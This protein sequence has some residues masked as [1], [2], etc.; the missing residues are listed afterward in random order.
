[1][2]RL[3]FTQR[4][5]LRSPHSPFSLLPRPAVRTTR[6]LSRR[7]LS[8]A[9]ESQDNLFEYTSGRWVYNDALRH[10]ERKVPSTPTPCAASPP[11]PGGFNRTLLVSPRGGQHVVARVP[12]AVTA[13][14]RLLRHRP[15]GGERRSRTCARAASPRLRYTAGVAEVVDVVRQ[16]AMLE[17]RMMALRFPTGDSLYFTTDL[18]KRFAEP[19]LPLRRERRP[20]YK[21]HPQS[22]AHHVP[23]HHTRPRPSGPA[24]SRF[25]MCHPDLRPA[26]IFVSRF[27]WQH[28]SVLPVFLLAGVPQSLHSRSGDRRPDCTARASHD[29][30]L[31]LPALDIGTAVRG[32]HSAQAGVYR[33]LRR[34]RRAPYVETRGMRVPAVRAHAASLSASSYRITRAGEDTIIS[35]APHVP[36]LMW[37]LHTALRPPAHA[38]GPGRPSVVLDPARSA[39]RAPRDEHIPHIPPRPDDTA[40]RTRIAPS[41]LESVDRLTAARPTWLTPRKPMSWRPTTSIDSV[42]PNYVSIYS[43]PSRASSAF[44]ACNALHY[45]AF[46]DPLYALCSRLFMHA[47][48]PWEGENADLTRALMQAA[49]RWDARGERA[50]FDVGDDGWVLS[51][52]YECVVASLRAFKEDAVAVLERAQERAEVVGKLPWDDMDEEG[53]SVDHRTDCTDRSSHDSVAQLHAGGAALHA[54]S[55]KVLLHRVCRGDRGGR[56]PGPGAL[57]ACA[58]RSAVPDSLLHITS[59]PPLLFVACLSPT[60]FR[61]PPRHCAPIWRWCLSRR[62]QGLYAPSRTARRAQDGGAPPLLQVREVARFSSHCARV[63]VCRCTRAVPPLVCC[64]GYRDCLAWVALGAGASRVMRMTRRAP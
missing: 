29:P 63:W 18:E 56:G 1:M 41:R 57:L 39:I 3:V 19:R 12:Y 4:K 34:A 45:A 35:S 17:S 5:A 25:S 54:G 22:P 44:P 31:M 59:A 13:P 8:T 58:T 47:G 60:A 49:D 9:P 48:G 27:D 26:N 10:M 36:A 21:Y 15:R 32:S 43:T 51:A 28:A 50:V 11:P 37:Y 61:K 2:L 62:S 30:A 40:S 16:L 64:A 24:L 46:T 14:G 23:P 7:A 33:A 20:A 6:S 38:Q 52:E 55:R 53:R 42:A